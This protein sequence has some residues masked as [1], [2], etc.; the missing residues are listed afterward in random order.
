MENPY[1]CKIDI[2]PGDIF[3]VDSKK[4]G[5]KIVKFFMT[6]PTIWHHIWRKIRG[7][8]EKVEYYHVGMFMTQAEIIEQQSKVVKK[9]SQKLLFTDDKVCIIRKKNLGNNQQLRLLEEA[10]DDVGK[11]Y[12][13]VNCIGKFLTWL[14]GIPYFA[15]YMETADDEICINRV[16]QWYKTAC[17]ETFGAKTH[18]E[19]TT[20]KLYKYVKAHRTRFQIVFEGIPSENNKK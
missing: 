11:S 13:V 18:H 5:P 20:H 7:T 6:A 16:A 2:K 12:D 9:S 3:L 19:L 4:K 1:Q 8:Q 15:R 17:N 14:T 10:L